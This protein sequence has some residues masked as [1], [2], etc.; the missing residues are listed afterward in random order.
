LHSLLSL[1]A[2]SASYALP[3][4]IANPAPAASS[5]DRFPRVALRPTAPPERREGGRGGRDVMSLLA[6]N[7][8]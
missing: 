7:C 3:S 6:E 4:T 8:T 2:L 1:Y 5:P